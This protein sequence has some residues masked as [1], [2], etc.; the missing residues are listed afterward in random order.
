ML[1][2]KVAGNRREGKN[3]YSATI[4]FRVSNLLSRNLLVVAEHGEVASH[5]VA[6]TV[7]ANHCP[8]GKKRRDSSVVS[9]RSH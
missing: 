2:G 1:P 8:E 7:S 5:K 4:L 6:V 3:Y 9:G